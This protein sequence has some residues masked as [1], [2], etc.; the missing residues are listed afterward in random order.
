MNGKGLQ[1]RISAMKPGIRV[2]FMSGY[3]A[4]VI[5]N[6]GIV[7]EG[8]NFISKPFSLQALTQKVRQVLE[9]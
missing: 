7:D 3:T 9:G 2:L 1:Q 5:T 4:D 6:R 8:I